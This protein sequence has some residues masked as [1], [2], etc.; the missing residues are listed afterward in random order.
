MS[1]W[2]SITRLLTYS[3]CLEFYIRIIAS[4]SIVFSLSLYSLHLRIF[5]IS[6]LSPSVELRGA[7]YIIILAAKLERSVLLAQ[8]ASSI[9]SL[10]FP[11]FRILPISTLLGSPSLHSPHF[12]I[13]FI[14]AFSL[15]LY[16]LYPCALFIPILSHLRTLLSSHPLYLSYTLI[17]T[18]SPSFILYILI[19]LVDLDFYHIYNYILTLSPNIYLSN[20]PLFIL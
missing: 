9:P 16:S 6:V 1:V 14:S 15:F 7:K 13:L 5:S 11:H 2:R 19:F 20:N 17:F 10:H 8:L 4:I 18:T 3:R 12:R